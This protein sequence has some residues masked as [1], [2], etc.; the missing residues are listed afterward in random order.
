MLNYFGIGENYLDFIVDKSEAKQGLYTPGTG[1]L[2]YPPEKIYQKNP[3]YLLVLCWNIADE[4]IEQ[5]KDYRNAGGKFIIPIP[6][7]QII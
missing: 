6:Q 7:I 2:V 1:L 4:V 5:L 3:D